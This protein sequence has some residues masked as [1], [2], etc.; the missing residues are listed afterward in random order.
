MTHIV[1]VKETDIRAP[2][3]L[4]LVLRNNIG[5]IMIWGVDIIFSNSYKGN[6]YLPMCRQ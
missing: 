6:V 4:A 2:S 3:I 1:S 5:E